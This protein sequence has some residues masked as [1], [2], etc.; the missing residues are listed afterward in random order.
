VCG[1]HGIPGVPGFAGKDGRPG[2]KGDVG[3]QGADGSKGDPGMK[4]LAGTDSGLYSNW[5]QCAWDRSVGKDNGLIQ[6]TYCLFD[7]MNCYI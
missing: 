1:S 7:E 5:K 2:P 4:G 3:P 6:V